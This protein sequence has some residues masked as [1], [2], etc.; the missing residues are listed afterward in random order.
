[1]GHVSDRGEVAI[2]LPGYSGDEV[3]VIILK[4]A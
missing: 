1:M 2:D 3:E 4:K